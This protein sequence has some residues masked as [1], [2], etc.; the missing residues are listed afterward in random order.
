MHQTINIDMG[1]MA[2]GYN[3]THIKTGSIGSCIVIVLYDYE[4]KIGGMAHAMLPSRGERQ[5]DLI[6]EA[7]AHINKT[8]FVARYADESVDRLIKE[9]E[10]IGGKRER[11]KAKLTGG[12]RM[13]KVLNGDKDG[14]G[15]Q[16]FESAKRRLQEL[17]IPIENEETGGTVGRVADLNLENGLVDVSTKM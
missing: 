13:F 7:R 4:A 8:E 3:G 11:L 15:Y 16:N 12:A 1:E 6:N 17:G 2:V 5:I 9:I 10:K 14:I